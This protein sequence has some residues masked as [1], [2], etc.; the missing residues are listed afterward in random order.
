MKTV[1]KFAP[2]ITQQ[3]IYVENYF[4]DLADK[5]LFLKKWSGFFAE[6]EVA[7][8]KET[9]Y[10]IVPKSV[11]KEEIEI[12][13]GSGWD[14]VCSKGISGEISVFC[15]VD[16]T[17]P[18]LFTDMG[19]YKAYM[20]KFTKS[21]LWNILLIPIMLLCYFVTLEVPRNYLEGPLHF[22]EDPIMCMLYVPIT[23]VFIYWLLHMIFDIR[24]YVQIKRSFEVKRNKAYQKVLGIW[25]TILIIW[26]ISLIMAIVGVLCTYSLNDSKEP[27]EHPVSLQELDVEEWN[28][29]Q[30]VMNNDDWTD[31]HEIF[32]EVDERHEM[33]MD[34][35]DVYTDSKETVYRAHYYEFRFDK[36][37]K[38]W[39]D[40]EIA[41]N[42]KQDLIYDG[43]E[44]P[45]IKIDDFV[46][47]IW[48]LGLEDDIRIPSDEVDYI[49]YYES[50]GEQN[51][52]IRDGK[53]IEIVGYAGSKKLLD[54]IDLFIADLKE[55]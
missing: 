43:D 20:K 30:S 33:W 1:K 6:F 5:G 22:F 13:N 28:S 7:E 24:I 48:K 23:L 32:Y 37:A 53:K 38:Q 10:R 36:L 15:T 51:L 14:Y 11:E 45:D 8:P 54:N 16:E 50:G 55:N 46:K 19:S 49:G 18:E 52:F 17:A 27:F 47:R 40:E 12:F 4:S 39:L 41:Y 34:A 3:M 42:I 29:I 35:V 44:T 26:I 25:K 2:Y 9:R 31:D 21:C